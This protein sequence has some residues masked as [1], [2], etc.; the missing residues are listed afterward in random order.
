MI[1][2]R[3]AF[4]LDQE[5]SDTPL[6]APLFGVSQSLLGRSWTGLSPLND[7]HALH[8]AQRLQLSDPLARVLSRLGV[9]IDEVPS[10][11]T[12]SLKE[13][14]PDPRAL[15]DMDAASKRI[16]TA[17]RNKERVAIFA[18]Y[19]VDG[20][21]SGAILFHWFLHFG[22][23]ASLY[24]PDR[25]KE[26]YGPN[27]EAIKALS[28]THDLII[29]VDCGTSAHQ[30][31][32]G[33]TS[34]II[35]LDHH[36]AGETL[37]PVYAVV[38][39]NRSDEENTLGAICA[40]GVVFMT[41]VQCNACLRDMA[42]DTP[43]LL[44]FLD[45][46]AL[47]T[48]ADVA[49][50]RG[51]NRAFVRQG[52]RVMRARARPGIVALCELAEVSSE[53]TPYHLGFV[54]GPRINAG[55]RVGAADLGI[56]LLTAETVE[57]AYPMAQK[58]HLLNEERK[59]IEASVQSAAEAQVMARKDQSELVWA[60]GDGWHPGVVGIVASRLKEQFKTPAFVF[61]FSG[62]IAK[63]SGRSVTG[64]DLGT[65]VQRLHHEGCID[66]GGG[67]AMAAGITLRRDQLAP[68]MARLKALLGQQSEP[69]DKRTTDM[70]IDATLQPRAI[71]LELLEDLEAAGPYGAGASAPR[72]VIPYLR[73]AFAK[74]VGDMHLKLSLKGDEGPTLDAIAFRAFETPIG[75]VLM[76]HDGAL[77]HIAA[78]L[79]IDT[80]SGR[81]KVKL[82]VEDAAK[83][84]MS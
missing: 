39:P 2:K 38:N 45:L 74:R 18:D 66:A 54:L 52:L 51:L 6:P 63:G 3:G 49:A 50:L 4:I 20:A 41:L 78:R 31:F 29:C 24:V 68:A 59:R 70:A 77:F 23:N 32:E 72:F 43:D 62:D 21:A 35:I 25:I 17:A 67:H 28:E 55:G 19:D 27:R 30:A 44:S 58:L 8:I 47:A 36:L 61:A 7:R 83:V 1:R 42:Q 82:H 40:A 15:K 64:V 48:V 10:Y 33:S 75:D 79:Q 80:W 56:R 57:N 9:E 84:A 71:T 37:P 69:S 73:V 60:A 13:L 12:P 5:T 46:V 53:I 34:D 76:N 11:L 81:K 22:V 26:G 14:M 65:A 16:V